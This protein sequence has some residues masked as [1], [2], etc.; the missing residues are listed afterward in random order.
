[1]STR[2]AVRMTWLVCGAEFFG[3][4]RSVLYDSLE[5]N[6]E[7][8]FGLLIRFSVHVTPVGTVIGGCNQGKMMGGEIRDMRCWSLR[9]VGG[10][11]R[12]RERES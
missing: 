1:M 3:V 2:V 6:P 12:G 11:G 9:E 10:G 5:G 4:E 7:A 8:G